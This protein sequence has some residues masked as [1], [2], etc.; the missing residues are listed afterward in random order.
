M[1]TAAGLCHAF[2]FPKCYLY[3]LTETVTY[4]TH[5]GQFTHLEKYYSECDDSCIMLALS[6]K[7]TL[8]GLPLTGD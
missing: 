2:Y 4:L 5:Q 6:P 3:G 1:L 8:M 7:I